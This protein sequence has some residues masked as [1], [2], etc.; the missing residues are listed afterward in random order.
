MLTPALNACAPWAIR[1][2]LELCSLL[3]LSDCA[4]IGSL[5]R[6]SEILVDFVFAEQKSSPHIS[7]HWSG[8]TKGVSASWAMSL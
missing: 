8:N 5:E 6:H 4:N 1:I 3:I 2:L 7:P